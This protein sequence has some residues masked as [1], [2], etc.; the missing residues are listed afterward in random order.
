MP[1][2]TSGNNIDISDPSPK[3][4]TLVMLSPSKTVI[5]LVEHIKNQ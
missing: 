4:G 3:G 1:A 5:N 2:P